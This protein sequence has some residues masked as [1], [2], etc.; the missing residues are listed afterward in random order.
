MFVK[1]LTGETTTLE[2]N[3]QR[4]ST[5]SKRRSKTRKGEW[6]PWY[7]SRCLSESPYFWLH[8]PSWLAR[9]NLCWQLRTRGPGGP[10]GVYASFYPSYLRGGMQIFVKTLTGKTTLE[11]ESYNIS[12]TSRL[13]SKTR[14]TWPETWQTPD[15]RRRGKQLEDGLASTLSDH[16]IQESTLSPCSSFMC[17]HVNFRQDFKFHW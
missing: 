17:W 11:F 3:P 10:K 7:I 8:R 9:F 13:R 16:N 5:T 1:T 15:L 12:I 14:W 4:R 2:F 6:F